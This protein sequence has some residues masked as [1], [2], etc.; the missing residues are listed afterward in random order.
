[1]PGIPSG[2]KDGTA[3]DAARDTEAR[4]AQERTIR[5]VVVGQLEL[6]DPDPLEAGGSVGRD[7][8][9]EGGGYRRDLAQGK[10]HGP[11]RLEPLESFIDR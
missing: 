6:P 1:M 11:G 5:L 9:L 3:G 8:L 2:K 4:L 7:I 10:P